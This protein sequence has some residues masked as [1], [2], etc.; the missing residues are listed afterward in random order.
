MNA[1]APGPPPIQR[2]TWSRWAAAIAIVFALHVV[3]I[4]IFGEYKPV[5]SVP[6][7]NTPS[8][9][10][11]NDSPGDWQA[12]NDPTLF[13]LPANNGFAGS[14]WA[15]IPLSLEPRRWPDKIEAP[16]WLSPTNSVLAASLGA[17]FNTFV[18]T[19]RYVAIHFEFSPPTQVAVPEVPAE[20]PLPGRS[21]MQ[22]E[23]GLAGRHL[24]TPVTLPA[25]EDTGVDA[26]SVVQVLVDA[27][28]NVVS[29][30]LLPQDIMTQ[31]NPWEPRLN[32]DKSADQWAVTMAR[33]LRFAE[34]PTDAARTNALSRLAIGQLIFNWRTMPVTTT[35]WAQYN[36]PL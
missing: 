2:W 11:V 10:L 3:L 26:P 4:F 24:L 18:Q 9:A 35:N 28:G 29:A 31:G 27:A 13:A 32:D 6:V 17:T 36:G 19:N 7:R 8:L 20:P 15:E 1:D 34:L 30:A 21:T 12:L 23:G 33:T 16:H 14:I 22:I 5:Q 25:W